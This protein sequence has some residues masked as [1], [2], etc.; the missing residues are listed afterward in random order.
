MRAK[1]VVANPIRQ[2]TLGH[3]VLTAIC[4]DDDLGSERNE[5]DDVGSDR[6]LPPEMKPECFQFAQLYPQLDFLW[7]EAFAKC[8]G[9][10]SSPRQLSS[11]PSPSWGGRARS[12]R[13]GGGSAHPV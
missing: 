13:V 5:V 11:Y 9:I 1:E 12:D 7:G 10:F 4:F 2:G 6:R 8:A 3:D